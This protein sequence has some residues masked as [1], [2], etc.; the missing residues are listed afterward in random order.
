[1]RPRVEKQHRREANKK[2][3]GRIFEKDVRL[4]WPFILGVA[5]ILNLGNAKST[6]TPHRR[7]LECRILGLA[8]TTFVY[9][10]RRIL[11]HCCVPPMLGLKL[12]LSLKMY[13]PLALAQTF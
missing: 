11:R 2:M 13:S 3:V 12:G 9:G 8:G 10:S 7:R 4:L 6:A 5:G 1:M